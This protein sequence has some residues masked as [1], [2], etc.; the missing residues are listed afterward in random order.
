MAEDELDR[1]PEKETLGQRIKRVRVQRGMS[2]AKVVR[3]DFSRAFLN[4]VELGKARPSIRVLRIIADRLGTEVEYLLEGQEAG[5]ERELALERGRV[6]V[7]RGEARKALLALKPAVTSY[8]WPLGSD[9]RVCQAQALL[10]LGR[11]TE[12]NAI[13]EQERRVIEL[14]ADSHRLQRL[15][16][17]E[18]GERFHFD[19]DVVEAHL[20]LADRATRKGANYDELEHYRAARVLLEAAARDPRKEP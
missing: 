16:A 12:A 5:V 18:R 19:G 13:L 7:A 2:L 11:T 3:D 1:Q 17:V 8:D 6:L 15:R 10:A 14:H 9:A 4:Q 20:H